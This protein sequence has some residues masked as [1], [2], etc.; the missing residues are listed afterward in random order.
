LV[1]PEAV[2]LAV[3]RGEEDLEQAVS[4]NVSGH[5]AVVDLIDVAER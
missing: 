3:V 1:E 2:K 5:G 4:V